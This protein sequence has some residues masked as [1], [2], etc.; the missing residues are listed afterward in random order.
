MAVRTP[1]VHP[2]FA[3]SFAAI[4]L[5]VS[6]PKFAS[7]RNMPIRKPKSPMRLTMKAFLP[8]SAADVLLE[9]EAD[10]Q[11]GCEAHA[12]PADK[13]QQ[14]IAGQ[15]QHRH[16]EQEEIQVAESSA[17]SPLRAPM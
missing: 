1:P 2:G 12:L 17:S 8:A 13:H 7:R 6:V 11:V 5:K 16:E 14:G 3:A 15:H 4:S 9:V 10:Q